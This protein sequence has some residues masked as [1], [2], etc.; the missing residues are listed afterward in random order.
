M[1]KSPQAKIYKWYY[2]HTHKAQIDFKSRLESH[3]QD[4][5]WYICK[6]SKI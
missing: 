3:P 4:S 2:T 5:L 1:K 6:Y